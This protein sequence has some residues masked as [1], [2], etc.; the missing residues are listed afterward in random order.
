MRPTPDKRRLLA[1]VPL[2]ASLEERDLDALLAVTTTRRLAPREELF[3][4]G[5]PGEQLY[6]VVSGRLKAKAEAADGKEVIFS[7]MGPQEVIGEI[8]LLDSN[9][10]SAT[11]EAIE[12]S[13]LLSL[14][15]REFLRVLERHPKV[16]IQLAGI[17]AGRLRRLSDLTEDTAFLTLPSRLA[18]K[19][20]ALAESDGLATPEGTRIEIRLPQSELGELVSTSRESVNKLLRAWVQEGVVGVDRGF[21]TLRKRR[22][23]EALA[24]L[25]FV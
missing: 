20:L 19:L 10:R 13:E 5:D 1:S 6:V 21:I 15:R 7:L 12:P 14:H 3:H 17:L 9:P 2:F 11:V 24:D 25:W 18:K 22:S 16:A 8:A 23:L 4:K